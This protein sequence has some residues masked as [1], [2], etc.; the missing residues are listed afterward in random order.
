[1]KQRPNSRDEMSIDDK[2]EALLDFMQE[3]H[4]SLG[5]H[6]WIRRFYPW[7]EDEADQINVECLCGIKR[8]A[9]REEYE[10]AEQPYDGY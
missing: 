1:M 7:E 6:H 10:S 2:L 8:K 5:M 9:T 3:V 4:E